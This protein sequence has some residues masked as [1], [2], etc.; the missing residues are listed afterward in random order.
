MISEEQYE[1][2]ITIG[3]MQRD[4][5]KWD[6]AFH[7]SKY[8]MKMTEDVGNWRIKRRQTQNSDKKSEAM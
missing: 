8:K 2:M 3:G 5:L 4:G 1:W 6:E 7:L